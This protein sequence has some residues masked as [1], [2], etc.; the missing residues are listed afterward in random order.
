MT[1][2]TA[3]IN[4]GFRYQIHA[5]DRKNPEHG[6]IIVNV[7]LDDYGSKVTVFDEGMVLIESPTRK[8]QYNL[9]DG[10]VVCE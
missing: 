9:K 10:S 8:I 7:E 6:L 4:R 2:G 1:K 5:T 3:Y